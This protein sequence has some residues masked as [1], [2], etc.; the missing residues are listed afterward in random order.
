MRPAVRVHPLPLFEHTGVSMATPSTSSTE[1]ESHRSGRHTWHRSDARLDRRMT[2]RGN[3]IINFSQ[4][5]K[6]SKRGE[7]SPEHINHGQVEKIPPGPNPQTEPLRTEL[8]R[9]NCPKVWQNPPEFQLHI[10]CHI[11]C[12]KRTCTHSCARSYTSHKYANE[13]KLI[14]ILIQT[15]TPTNTQS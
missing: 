14:Q 8:P 12:D 5:Q 13:R 3:F 10:S 6:P 9:K 11:Y 4:Q 15:H 1:P 7:Y 2:M